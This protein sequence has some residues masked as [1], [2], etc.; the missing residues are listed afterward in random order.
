MRL[1]HAMPHTGISVSGNAANRS[2]QRR[3]DG[4]PGALPWHAFFPTGK[5]AERVRFFLQLHD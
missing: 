3:F 1:R 2:K 4:G 5:K